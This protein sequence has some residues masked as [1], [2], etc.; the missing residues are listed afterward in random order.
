MGSDIAK[1]CGGK[2]KEIKRPLYQPLT[3][4]SLNNENPSD[5]T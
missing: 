1:I 4:P 3:N 2:K 5:S